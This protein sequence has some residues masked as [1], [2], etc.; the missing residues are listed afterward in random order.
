MKGRKAKQKKKMGV[1]ED[2][3]EEEKKIK[4][5]EGK[6]KRPKKVKRKIFCLVM[7]GV[8]GGGTLVWVAAKADAKVTSQRIPACP[9][10]SQMCRYTR[11][12]V[13]SILQRVCQMV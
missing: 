5:K 10:V 8:S 4:I 6:K 11:D 3:E 9:S 2:E 12:A 13:F 7:V 1:A